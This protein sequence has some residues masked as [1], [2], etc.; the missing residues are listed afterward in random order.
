MVVK[1]GQHNI[2]KQSVSYYNDDLF[3]VSIS[4]HPIFNVA[5]YPIITQVVLVVCITCIIMKH[6]QNT[7][8][9]RTKPKRKVVIESSNV[10]VIF[11]II[12]YYILLIRRDTYEYVYWYCK[13]N[14]ENKI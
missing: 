10:L 11:I 4:V 6:D 5:P 14:R 8:V 9:Q 7:K 2:T 12:I 1:G 3:N 13:F